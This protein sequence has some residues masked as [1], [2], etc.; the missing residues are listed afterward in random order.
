METVSASGLQPDQIDSIIRT[1]GS[2][3]IPVFYEMLGRLF[4]PDKVRTIDTFS[5]VTAGLGISAYRVE[6]GELD[7]AA[8]YGR[9]IAHTG[10][11]TGGRLKVRPVNLEL[12]QRRIALEE[13][14]SRRTNRRRPRTQALVLVGEAGSK[15]RMRRSDVMAVL[16]RRTSCPPCPM[17]WRQPVRQALVADLDDQTRVRHHALPLPANNRPATGGCRSAQPTLGRSAPVGP[18]RGGLRRGQ[19]VV[20][21]RV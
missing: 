17:Q 5:S 14:E 20:R 13:Q 8:P 2:A 19:L 7:L 3:Q 21:A 1:G 10:E 6:Q 12:L 9:R 18:T 15:S 4:G 16:C 11:T